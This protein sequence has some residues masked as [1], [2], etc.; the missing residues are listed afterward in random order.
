MACPLYAIGAL[1]TVCLLEG[2]E[3]TLAHPHAV[4]ASPHRKKLTVSGATAPRVGSA[5][6]EAATASR[7]VCSAVHQMMS[8][9]FVFVKMVGLGAAARPS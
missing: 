6:R 8:C 7:A 3:A 9:G 5:T 1:S 2:V 4:D